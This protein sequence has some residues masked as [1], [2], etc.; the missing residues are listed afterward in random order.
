MY[1]QDLLSFIFANRYFCVDILSASLT[2]LLI[3]SDNFLLEDAFFLN[4]IIAFMIA[5]ALIKFVVIRKL[6]ASMI[7][8]IILW[9]FFVL[10]Q[11]ALNF[12][13]QN[14]QQSL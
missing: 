7:P 5:G 12:K 6:K 4:D 11:F 1:T 2:L 13:L 14:Y 3:G 9:I 8:L 10:R